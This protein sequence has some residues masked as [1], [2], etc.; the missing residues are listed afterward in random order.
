MPV[1]PPPI[2]PP[3]L[4]DTVTQFLGPFGVFITVVAGA[5]AT[6][7]LPLKALLANR[8][9]QETD[10]AKA[11]RDE[12]RDELRRA[13]EEVSQLREEISELFERNLALKHENNN[14]KMQVE[15]LERRVGN[16]HTAVTST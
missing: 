7:F 6:A 11:F 8:A 13:R 14:L 12:L 10:A 5:I 9:A 1:Q 2:P 15:S 16:L 4:L 3:G